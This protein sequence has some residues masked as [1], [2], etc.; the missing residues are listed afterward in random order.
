MTSIAWIGSNR[1]EFDGTST[2]S[3]V[4]EVREFSPGE[5]NSLYRHPFVVHPNSVSYRTGVLYS[6]G[7]WPATAGGEDLALWLRVARE[8]YAWWAR[9]AGLITLPLDQTIFAMG[10]LST[11]RS[12]SSWRDTSVS[13]L[14]RSL[15]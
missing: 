9:L 1:V 4:N 14:R 11:A 5:V 2:G 3:W 10:V 15:T 12:S 13:R 7:G 8:R 6:V